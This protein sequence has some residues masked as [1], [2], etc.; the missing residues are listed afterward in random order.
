MWLIF[1]EHCF[2]F[3]SSA[4]PTEPVPAPTSAPVPAP[5][6]TPA[7]ASAPTPAP[8]TRQA[9]VGE[10]VCLELEVAADAGE[11]VWHKGTERIQP[12]GH[13]EILSQGQRQMLVIKGFKTE[14]QG[15][16]RCCPTR[17]PPSSGTATFNGESEL[18]GWMLWSGEELIW[19]FFLMCSGHKAESFPRLHAMCREKKAWPGKAGLM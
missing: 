18:W 10:D 5:T 13:F 19:I 1:C 14:D 9:V 12:S 11:V 8:E 2:F 7:K 15:E 4:E 6:P 16:Y 3:F 17:G